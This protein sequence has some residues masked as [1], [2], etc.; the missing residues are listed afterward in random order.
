M[1]GS[2]HMKKFAAVIIGLLLGATSPAFS[3]G[4]DARGPAPAV[5][6]PALVTAPVAVTT[7]P[8]P[9]PAPALVT[10]LPTP[11]DPGPVIEDPGFL[12]RLV[13]LWRSGA[14]FPTAILIAF[15]L[16][17]I[18]RRRIA[19]LNDDHRVAYTAAGI[20][21]LGK[22]ADIAATGVTPN[23]NAIIGALAGV[24]LL[25]IKAKPE[26][27]PPK[28]EATKEVEA[29]KATEEVLE[30]APTHPESPVIDKT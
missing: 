9:A 6:A 7:T 23:Q 19:W 29:P 13:S 4:T 26:P 21:G 2:L 16:A 30:R 5:V 14:G 10:T 18:A 22:L 8:A 28:A 11:A 25:A 3:A 20:A 17:L 1:V 24:W 12:D 27:L 15:G